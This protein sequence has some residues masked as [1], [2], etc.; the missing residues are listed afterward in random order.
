M[1]VKQ[2]VQAAL[3]TAQPGDT[4]NVAAG[5][6]KQNLVFRRPGRADAPITLRGAGA[7]AT[8]IQ[9]SVRIQA[10]HIVIQS[11]AVDP[12][13]DDDAVWLEASAQNIYLQNLHLYGSKMY[14]VRIENAVQNV[15]I[16]NSEINNFDAG[17]SDAHGIGIKTASNITIRGCNIHHNSGD[18]IQI[19]TPD[20][21]GYNRFASTIL[22]ENNDLH[23]N[24]ENAVDI[25]STHTAIV[26]NN[27]IWAVR[28]ADS[29]D[30]MAI[31]VQYDA[32]DISILGNHIWDAVQG[33]EIT[34]GNKNGKEY[35]VAPSRVL[36]AGNLIHDLVSEGSDSARGSGIIVRTSQDTKVY[37]NTIIRAAAAAV[38]LA[39]S[40]EDAIPTGID[41]RN[42]VLHG[43]TND[44]YLA[45]NATLFPKLR[46]D[47]NHYV[48]GRVR[49]DSLTTWLALGYEQHATQGDPLLGEDFRP[50]PG[51]PLINSA[52]DVGLA[53][54]G[55]AP[56]RG[57]GELAP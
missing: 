41:L 16:E 42:N 47:F 19:N 4:I 26:R 24:R 36:L 28:V 10:A 5:T 40:A 2:D 49:G 15:L 6:L 45:R 12:D 23:H 44:L 22:I 20:Y 34:R 1:T 7:D 17:D 46:V 31:Q 35:P 29:S 37:N 13:S 18:A 38:Y 33:I 43:N 14:G 27:R 48:S 39:Y 52:T 57:W 54:S 51:S 8:I 32:Q 50:L 9:G 21:P 11:L 30:G 56:D 55:A 25:K 3:D 53:F